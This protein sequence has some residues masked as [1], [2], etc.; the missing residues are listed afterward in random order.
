MLNTDKKRPLIND[1]ERAER[2]R[3]VID[4][5]HEANKSVPVIVEGKKDAVALKQLGLSGEMIILHRG[6]G[7]YEFCEDIAGRFAKVILLMDWDTRGERLYKSIS[8]S[9]GGHWE[10]FAP[11]RET[12]KI[13]CRKDIN[14]IE[15]IPKLLSRLEGNEH[16]RQGG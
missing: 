7:L 12:I 15:G 2:L 1:L 4:L 11:L 8:E 10:E 3:K 16:T 6:K 14:D 9:L 13:L 5:L